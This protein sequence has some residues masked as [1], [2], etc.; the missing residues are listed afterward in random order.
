MTRWP[1][2]DRE[3]FFSQVEKN[4]PIIREEIGPCWIWTGSK[5]H[6][7]YGKVRM[8]GREFRAHRASWVLRYG[9]IRPDVI[10]C[11]RCDNP[12][13]VNPDHLFIGSVADNMRDMK[14]KGRAKGPPSA[15]TNTAVLDDE[16]AFLV[17]VLR[18]DGW[19]RKELASRFGLTTTSIDNVVSGRTWKRVGFPIARTPNDETG[20][21]K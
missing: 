11:H 16:T 4:G 18:A 10:A 1:L 3:R 17:R 14:L 21:S 9:F 13:C 19:G 20:A 15:K 7:G 5:T 12:P 2:S 6:D 8:M